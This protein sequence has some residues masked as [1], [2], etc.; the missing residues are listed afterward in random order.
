MP[1]SEIEIQES[2]GAIMVRA[3]DNAGTQHRYWFDETDKDRLVL[4][5]EVLQIDEVDGFQLGREFV[6][7]PMVPQNVQDELL[8]EGYD[9]ETIYDTD[10]RPL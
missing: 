4:C 8:E 10:G 7:N 2:C 1:Q 3:W 5:A 9:A 6:E